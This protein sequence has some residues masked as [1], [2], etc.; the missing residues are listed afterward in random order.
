MTAARVA[1]QLTAQLAEVGRLANV[2]RGLA[3]GAA[4]LCDEI[5]TD[6]ERLA[7]RLIA[8]YRAP[9]EFTAGLVSDLVRFQRAAAQ[10]QEDGGR[11]RA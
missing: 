7:I 8:E 6:T 5:V 9:E 11:D 10:E 4:K 1:A 3:P 2:L